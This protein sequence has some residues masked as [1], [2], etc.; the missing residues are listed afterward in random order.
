M[1]CS[2]RSSAAVCCQPFVKPWH[3]TAEKLSLHTSMFLHSFF[4]S[5]V[6]K[7]DG[8]KPVG[9]IAA[10]TICSWNH[11]LIF[12]NFE[13]CQWKKHYFSVTQF[14]YKWLKIHV[15]SYCLSNYWYQRKNRISYWKNRWVVKLKND[16][17]IQIWIHV[18]LLQLLSELF[19]KGWQCKMFSR[20]ISLSL[21][22]PSLHVSSSGFRHWHAATPINSC[23]WGRR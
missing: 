13:L 16:R 21:P 23:L 7:V 2:L 9:F 15:Y 12:M 22:D 8:I 18:C 14:I 17:V 20:D 11:S 19:T 1:C 4:H 5:G 3:N 6:R 10:D